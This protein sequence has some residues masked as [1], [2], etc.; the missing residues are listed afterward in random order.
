MTARWLLILFMTVS[1]GAALAAPHP[2]TGS[3][4][5]TDPAKGL[6]AHGFGFRL[7]DLADTWIPVPVL[8]ESPLESLRFEPKLAQ[9]E[10]SDAAISIH[11]EKMDRKQ[12]LESY[13]RKWIRE[14]PNYGFE[15]LGTKGVLI[16]GQKALLVD[17]TQNNK[18]RQIRQT[19]L[20]DQD[21]VMI[22]TCLDRK[23]QFQQTLSACNRLLR[24]LE[25]LP[26]TH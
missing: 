26:E 10:K 15:M 19:V 18:N 1:T 6:F 2:A 5:L 23:D 14:Y 9:G 17:L 25:W 21:R 13:A 8:T 22:V 12:S 11:F 24:G 3:S 20:Q 16:R 7:H 4:L